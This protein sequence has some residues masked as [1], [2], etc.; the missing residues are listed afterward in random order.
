MNRTSSDE[1]EEDD[2]DGDNV[3]NNVVIVVVVV[4][5]VVVNDDDEEE[6]DEDGA[7]THDQTTVARVSARSIQQSWLL[8]KITSASTTKSSKRDCGIGIVVLLTL[9]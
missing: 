4:V 1:E 5:A 9:L 7:D 6:D 3:E 8:G 2:D